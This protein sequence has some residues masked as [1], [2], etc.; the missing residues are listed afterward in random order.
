MDGNGNNKNFK[1]TD[2]RSPFYVH[3]SDNLGIVLTSVSLRDEVNYDNWSK[4]MK[5]V[6]K[7]KNKMGF[8]N[9]LIKKPPKSRLSR[10]RAT[11]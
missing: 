6:L 7:G 10:S 5:N 3:A 2:P 1:V 8:I 9:S 4:A 11:S